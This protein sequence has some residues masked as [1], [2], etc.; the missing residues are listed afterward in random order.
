MRARRHIR[1]TVALDTSSA[2]LSKTRCARSGCRHV[3]RAER[4]CAALACGG[5]YE[6]EQGREEVFRRHRFSILRR[7]VRSFGTTRVRPAVGQRG[8]G[9]AASMPS[10]AGSPRVRVTSGTRVECRSNGR[11]LWQ[12][13]ARPLDAGETMHGR[14]PAPRCANVRRRGSSTDRRAI[15]HMILRSGRTVKP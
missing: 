7:V 12:A 3:A 5:T 11:A 14:A 13:S 4:W 15:G 9:A 1:P 8:G 10:G 2:R 6:V